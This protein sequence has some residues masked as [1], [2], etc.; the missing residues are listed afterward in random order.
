MA[1]CVRAGAAQ[2]AGHVRQGVLGAVVHRFLSM[3]IKYIRKKYLH[4]QTD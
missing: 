2:H 1:Q 4:K 3:E